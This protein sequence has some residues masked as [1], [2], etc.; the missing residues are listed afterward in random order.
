MLASSV[1]PSADATKALRAVLKHR[2]STNR[3]TVAAASFHV[4]ARSGRPSR[5]AIRASRSQPAQH[6]TLENA[7]TRRRPRS[8]HSPASGWSWTCNARRAQ[9][10][11][12]LE[13]RQVAALHETL[14]EKHVR[15]REDRGA[16]D[17]VLHL[18]EG[19]VADAHG[20]HAVIAGER[21][22]DA[23]GQHRIAA[24]CVNGLQFVAG[25]ARGDI[26]DIGQ[27]AL[28]RG[29]R[30]QAVERID[31]EVAV[32]QPA[33]AIVPVAPAAW[34]FG[35]RRRHGGDDRAGVV[36]GVLLEGDGGADD[37][38]LPF[39]WDAEAAHP[40]APAGDRLVDEPRGRPRRCPR[41]LFRRAP[42]AASA[43]RPAETP[44]PPES[45]SASR[46]S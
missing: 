36:E 26:R 5:I 22:D 4:S 8:S 34:R 12:A 14:V 17:V 16:V 25:G 6:I 11:E 41:R 33:I 39:E 38:G 1:S 20:P 21:V 43:C 19:R 40:V 35:D 42:A 10:L 32:A 28:H 15:C 13:E 30:T 27:V 37:S 7:C 44:V 3:R 18:L 46:R 29:R 31:D 9:R 24:D 45:P 2:P 23:L